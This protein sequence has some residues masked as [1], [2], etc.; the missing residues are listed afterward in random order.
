MICN[1]W[2]LAVHV[3]LFSLAIGGTI[4]VVHAEPNC[5]TALGRAAKARVSKA[6][7]DNK[8]QACNGL[9]KG[10][11][12][13]DKTKKL[14]LNSFKLCEDGSV[15]SAEITIDVSC[16]IS[17]PALLSVSVDESLT[18]TASADLDSCR[19]IDADVS[20]AGR[21]GAMGIKWA[22]LAKKFR[23]AAER[24]IQAYCK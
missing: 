18:A 7:S 21:L 22:D 6:I 10:P 8:D 15:V 23:E 12:G 11:I 13:I 17:R 1:P 9:K 14:E 3:I 2:R 19:V 4:T 16:G 20:A 5:D 24:E